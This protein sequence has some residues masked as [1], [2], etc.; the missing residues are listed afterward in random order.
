MGFSKN[1]A[2]PAQFLP[3]RAL[4]T[5]LFCDG[6]ERSPAQILWDSAADPSSRAAVSGKRRGLQLDWEI[7]DL[8]KFTPRSRLAGSLFPPRMA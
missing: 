7:P 1:F 8:T 3:R 5:A 2:G 6:D 4:G